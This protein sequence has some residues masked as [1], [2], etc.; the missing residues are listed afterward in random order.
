MQ[1]IFKKEYLPQ[2]KRV[3]DYIDALPDQEYTPDIISVMASSFPFYVH[4][5]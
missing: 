3:I 2:I 4:H 5:L 1:I